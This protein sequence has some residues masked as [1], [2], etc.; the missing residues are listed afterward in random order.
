MKNKFIY[1]YFIYISQQIAYLVTQHPEFTN[2]SL[3]FKISLRFHST[4]MN[5]ISFELPG[6]S[7]AF[8]AIK[9]KKRMTD[10]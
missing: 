2:I 6:Y 9:F 4:I 3:I 5:K 1:Q 7:M 8:T 10:Q